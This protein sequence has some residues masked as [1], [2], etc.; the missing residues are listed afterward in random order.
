MGGTSDASEGTTAGGQGPSDIPE[1]SVSSESEL[2]MSKFVA[3]RDRKQ[4]ED[5]RKE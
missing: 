3:D 5:A 2:A 1:E 4:D